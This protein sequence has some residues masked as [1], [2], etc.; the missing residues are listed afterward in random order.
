MDEILRDD[1]QSGDQEDMYDVLWRR[2][3]LN[4][5]YIASEAIASN[6]QI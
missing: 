6:H 3:M 2:L 4:D 5:V 1:K